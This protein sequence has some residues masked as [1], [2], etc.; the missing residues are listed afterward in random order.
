MRPGPGPISTVKLGANED[1]R[2]AGER[3]LVDP[4]DSDALWLGTRH[5]GLLQL[6]GPGCHLGVGRLPGH[7]V[8]ATGQGIM[9][10]VAAGRSVY[11]GWG[12]GDGTSGTAN[13][14]NADRTAWEAVPGQPSGG[15]AASKVPIR[16]AYDTQHPRAVRDVRGRTRPQRP[17][18]RRV[19]KLAPST[20]SWTD[21]TPVKP[22]RHHSDGSADTF[23]YGGVAVD[24]CRAGTVV[25]STNN[26]W[27]ARSTPSS[28]PPT[29]AV[30]GRP[31]RT[32]R[33]STCRR[34]RTSSWGGDKPKF[35]WWI[36]AL[37][38]DPYD[39]KHIV[40]GTGA[41]LY[42]T[43]D[44]DALGAADPRPGGDRPCAS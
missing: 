8:G 31:S 33:S 41:T 7:T 35:G 14:T 26:R 39:S 42:G 13:R 19:H 10:L 18:R 6:H 16:A 40:Y 23:G 30:P 21:V 11:A 20:G 9:F 22:R 34:L 17:V 43:R 24:A 36:Q 27:V 28:G 37:A 3:L 2:G 12:D 32:L 44:L 29:A 1:G 5:D 38:V 15:A 25:V 4:R